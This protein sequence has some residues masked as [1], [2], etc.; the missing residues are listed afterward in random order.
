MFFLV[1]WLGDDLNWYHPL[2]DL[3][4]GDQFLDLEASSG[5][6]LGRSCSLIDILFEKWCALGRGG[7]TLKEI[8]LSMTGDFHRRPLS[9]GHMLYEVWLISKKNLLKFTWLSFLPFLSWYTILSKGVYIESFINLCEVY[10]KLNFSVWEF[11]ALCKKL[12][13]TRSEY[14]ALN[15]NQ[16][17][18]VVLIVKQNNWKS[19]PQKSF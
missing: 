16:G 4:C 18:H 8:C 2:N 3:L 10:W 6:S 5:T 17:V 11:N 13:S 12:R 1:V 15:L 9:K 14:L 19:T 7:L